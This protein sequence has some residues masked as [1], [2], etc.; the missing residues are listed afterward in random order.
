MAGVK[1]RFLWLFIVVSVVATTAILLAM[2]A[3]D[4]GSAALG[5]LA[6][7]LIALLG[8]VMLARVV[9]VVERRRWRP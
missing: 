8:I 5:A 9:V 3:A 4:H 2:R 1:R 6:A 7:G